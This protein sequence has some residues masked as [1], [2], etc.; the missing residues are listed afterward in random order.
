[1][2]LDKINKS[3]EN[4]VKEEKATSGA[5]T[6]KALGEAAGQF[7]A[8]GDPTPVNQKL[9][10]IS[11]LGHSEQLLKKEDV[12]E[13]RIALPLQF[14]PYL[15]LR[16]TLGEIKDVLKSKFKIVTDVYSY[17]GHVVAELNK[18]FILKEPELK[19]LSDL[20]KNAIENHINFD[21]LPAELIT[22]TEDKKLKYFDDKFGVILDLKLVLANLI[23]PNNIYI[24]NIVY[25]DEEKANIVRDII[26]KCK[27]ASES[28][29]E[30]A[31]FMVEFVKV[32]EEKIYF[33][34]KYRNFIWSS[35]SMSLEH[36]KVLA[37]GAIKAIDSKSTVVFRPL[38]NILKNAD[39]N[40]AKSKA[41][42]K[43]KT[44][45]YDEVPV[46]K[47]S[48]QYMTGATGTNKTLYSGQYLVDRIAD[49]KIISL[50]FN[51]L[52]NEDV[53]IMSDEVSG[54]VY[55][56]PDLFKMLQYTVLRRVSENTNG[57]YVFSPFITAAIRVN[58]VV[59]DGDIR[60]V[61]T[62]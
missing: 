12:R 26:S 54:T 49:R 35:L 60:I 61:F 14:V 29:K 24:D 13:I 44:V 10:S 45:A 46:I 32:P 40:S 56:I 1:M 15:D 11:L 43:S 9:G 37:N 57:E 41:L 33:I 3:V 4:A 58:L 31:D 51:E 55:L 42:I 7:P 25:N 52:V 18:E 48:G 17:G 30:V 34:S 36:F 59:E 16:Y 2:S 62:A 6:K 19:F 21:A 50:T 47:L 39:K 53:I 23:L 22:L 20:G 28:G 8:Y 38:A 5:R 27:V